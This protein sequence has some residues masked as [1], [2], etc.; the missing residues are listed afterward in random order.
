[1]R[2]GRIKYGCAHI[3]A[4]NRN[5]TST[6]L[7]CT[8]NTYKMCPRP[9]KEIKGYAANTPPF[10]LYFHRSANNDLLDAQLKSV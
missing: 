5:M 4:K 9:K 7:D 10:R 8:K 3:F 2:F 6:L 1:M